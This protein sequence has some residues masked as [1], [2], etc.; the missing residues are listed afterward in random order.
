MS[1]A[2][3]SS[4]ATGSGLIDGLDA[5]SVVVGGGSET[6]SDGGPYFAAAA[7][8]GTQWA[9]SASGNW[10]TAAN[11]TNGVPDST[12]DA[13]LPNLSNTFYTV[14]LTAGGTA[15]SLTIADTRAQ[16]QI[17][18]TGGLP[19]TNLTI[20]SGLTNSGYTYVDYTGSGGSTV[21]IGG[22]LTDNYYM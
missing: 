15:N 2:T 13:T 16:L 9:V 8:G 20:Q 10:N 3:Y 22:T 12:L 21:N 18:T 17:Y 1:D 14:S 6:A 5:G 7:S 4:G 11:W 19:P